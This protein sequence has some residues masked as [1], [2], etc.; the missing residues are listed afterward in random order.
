MPYPV[1]AGD[2]IHVLESISTFA[3]VEPATLAGLAR[4]AVC[5]R[6]QPGEIVFLEGDPCAGL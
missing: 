4:A 1:P 3:G 5:R 2:A 6:Y